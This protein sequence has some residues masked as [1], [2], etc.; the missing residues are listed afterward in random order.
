VPGAKPQYPPEFKTEAIRLVHS[1]GR[2]ISQVA[3]ELGVSDNSLRNWVRQAQIDEGKSE[4]LTTEER[5]EL[6]RL[7]RE[8]KIL[9]Q[10]KDILKKA[11]A[12]FAREEG[13]R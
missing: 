9:R 13:I 3:K 4:G 11:A 7:R 2:S 10:E 12:F 6:K 5:E 8:V 1:S